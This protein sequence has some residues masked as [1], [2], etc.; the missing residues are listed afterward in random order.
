MSKS[1]Y[2]MV[3]V[4]GYV[5]AL[6][7]EYNVTISDP[8]LMIWEA[9]DQAYDIIE[10]MLKQY[11]VDEYDIYTEWEMNSLFG[12]NIIKVRVNM[13]VP[14]EASGYDE[15]LSLAENYVDDFTEPEG[16]YGISIGV[17]DAELKADRGMLQR[18]KGA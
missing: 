15:A 7:A 1:Y 12:G 6:N 11:D 18:C 13:V 9:E 10:G 2:R 16:V 17:W 14:V 4:R 5:V 3:N 8:D